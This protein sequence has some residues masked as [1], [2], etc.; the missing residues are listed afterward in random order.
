METIARLII[1][2]AVAALLIG[3]LVTAEGAQFEPNC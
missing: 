3:T 1:A 2:C